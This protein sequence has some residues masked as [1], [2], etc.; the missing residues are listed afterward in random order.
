MF[1][2]NLWK[3]SAKEILDFV[4][5]ILWTA[6][7][8]IELPVFFGILESWFIY[9]FFLHCVICFNFSK[10]LVW[11]G[12]LLMQAIFCR[13]H[14][15]CCKRCMS[16]LFFPNMCLQILKLLF[17]ANSHHLHHHFILVSFQSCDLLIEEWECWT[18]EEAAVEGP[19]LFVARLYF[20]V[21]Q[22]VAY[23]GHVYNRWLSTWTQLE[24]VFTFDEQD[25]E[26]R[27]SL[28]PC[29]R[30]GS[31]IILCREE[32]QIRTT[33]FWA[34]MELLQEATVLAHSY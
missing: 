32:K 24:M 34:Q 13:K 12:W 15:C 20:H 33:A 9:F 25:P 4:Q 26:T 30:V 10:R 16:T 23:W 18:P 28:C 1:T 17:L 11:W 19:V 5:K 8:E 7:C 29:L 22:N 2:K 3:P 14:R 27:F 31:Y 21:C 6:Q